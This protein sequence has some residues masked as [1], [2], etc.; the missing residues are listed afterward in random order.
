MNL[1]D[2]TTRRSCFRFSLR[3]LFVVV[4]LVGIL[5][6]WIAYNLEWVHERRKALEI[7]RHVKSPL[8]AVNFAGPTSPPNHFPLGLRLLG[9]QKLHTIYLEVAKGDIS[10]IKASHKIKRIFP[11]AHVVCQ[12]PYRQV[13]T[14]NANP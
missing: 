6:A 3:T 1:T 2:N 10:A 7:L 14:L 4:G 5:A 8:T 11:E 9:E 13:P 12:E